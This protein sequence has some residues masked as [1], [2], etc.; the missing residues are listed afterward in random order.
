MVVARRVCRTD[1]AAA[2]E[3]YRA[4][5]TIDVDESKRDSRDI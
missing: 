2:L 5:R 1:P 3:A 4:Y